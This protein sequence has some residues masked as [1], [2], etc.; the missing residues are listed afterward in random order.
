MGHQQAD[1]IYIIEVS[2]EKDKNKESDK[3]F[4]SNFSNLRKVIVIQIQEIKKKTPSSINVKNSTQ[5]H[6]IIK[7]S[8]DKNKERWS[9]T[10]KVT[11]HTK[12]ILN[13][14]IR[15]FHSRKFVGKKEVW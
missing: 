4:E 15:G 11:H 13:K 12:G 10:V 1:S 6:I 9:E 2:E 8:K 5:R 3:W 7:L 14:I